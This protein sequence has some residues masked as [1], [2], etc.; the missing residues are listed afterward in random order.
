MSSEDNIHEPNLAFQVRNPRLP[1][2][3]NEVL[4]GVLANR[5]AD[6]ARIGLGLEDE[7]SLLKLMM[8]IL[9][10]SPCYTISQLPPRR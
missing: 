8:A 7:Y 10:S 2:F 6:H 1:R 5:R 4:L 9:M 3:H